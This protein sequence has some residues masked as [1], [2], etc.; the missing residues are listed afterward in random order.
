MARYLPAEAMYQMADLFRDRCLA[1]GRSL[2]WP[3]DEVWT[4]LNISEVVSAFDEDVKGGSFFEK[5]CNQLAACS[6][7]AHKVAADVLVL[8]E[9]ILWPGDGAAM[10]PSTKM[11]NLETVMSWKLANQPPDMT[12]LKQA[13]NVGCTHPGVFYLGPGRP[14]QLIFF[15]EF[16]RAAREHGIDPTDSVACK[17]LADDVKDGTKFNTS[18]A[19][20]L[21]LHLLFPDFFEP[22]VEN[23]KHK[24]AEAMKNYAGEATDLDDKIFNIRQALSKKLGKQGWSFYE[25]DVLPLWQ[26]GG[27]PEPPVPDPV[28]KEIADLL[29]T[30]SLKDS[31]ILTDNG[32]RKLVIP[33]TRPFLKSVSGLMNKA[34][35]ELKYHTGGEAKTKRDSF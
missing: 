18:A 3:S 14:W 6:Q 32:W 7:D 17:S 31:D 21:L 1:N 25:D 13:F 2:L 16:A 26:N 15:L 19:R 8:Y 4:P 9:L 24:L 35:S 11:S 22:M 28:L 29:E 27:S 5:W 10:K 23:H 34:G 33:V 12:L 20:H 30:H